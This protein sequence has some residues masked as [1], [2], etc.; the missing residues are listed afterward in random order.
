MVL[1]VLF[2]GKEWRLKIQRTDLWTQLEMEKVEQ[3]EEVA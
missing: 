2:A 3:V 1:M